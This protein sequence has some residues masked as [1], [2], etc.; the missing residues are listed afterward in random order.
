MTIEEVDDIIQKLEPLGITIE[1]RIIPA[2]CTPCYDHCW[3]R[4][5]VWKISHENKD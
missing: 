3:P 1:K 4:S 2:G 5:C